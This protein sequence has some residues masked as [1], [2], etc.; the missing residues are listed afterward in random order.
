MGPRKKAKNYY[1]IKKIMSENYSD[2]VSTSEKLDL[3]LNGE[4]LT[5]DSRN[6]CDIIN[7]DFNQLTADEK[8]SFDVIKILII[9]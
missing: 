2:D 5:S 9:R 6:C 4:Q 7:E 1:A 8:N 3:K